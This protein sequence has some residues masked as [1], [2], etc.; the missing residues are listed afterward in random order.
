MSKDLSK[1]IFISSEEKHRV[2]KKR[3]QDIDMMVSSI[4]DEI[5][6]NQNLVVNMVDIKVFDDYTYYHSVNVAILSIVMD[7]AKDQEAPTL[8]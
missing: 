4:V 6:A 8:D 1:N 3:V 2:G 5:L 7:V